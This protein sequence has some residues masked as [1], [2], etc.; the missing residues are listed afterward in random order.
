M[1][2]LVPLLNQF[3]SNLQNGDQQRCSIFS[4]ELCV[5]RCS[6]SGYWAVLE[7]PGALVPLELACCRSTS[8]KPCKRTRGVLMD[9]QTPSEDACD[10]LLE[11]HQQAV[12]VSY[13]FVELLDGST[14]A[15]PAGSTDSP[16][17]SRPRLSPTPA[18]V[19]Y[20]R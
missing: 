20:Q 3:R 11:G 18:A 16:K 10:D 4:N 1:V 14:Y 9:H 15:A 17:P 7:L 12:R 13:A 2:L 8:F 5:L 6:R 19:A